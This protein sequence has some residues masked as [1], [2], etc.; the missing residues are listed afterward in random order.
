MAG[1]DEGRRTDMKKIEEIRQWI[2]VCEKSGIGVPEHVHLLDAYARL[3]EAR[4][5]SLTG[6]VEKWKGRE[7]GM[8]KNHLDELELRV[9]LEAKIAAMTVDNGNM[10]VIVDDYRRVM[11]LVGPVDVEIMEANLSTLSEVPGEANDAAPKV[12]PGGR[13]EAS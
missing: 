1:D 3:L 12:G 2:E 8:A 11:C 4:I 7:A 13:G 6:E 10:E 9:G 5:V